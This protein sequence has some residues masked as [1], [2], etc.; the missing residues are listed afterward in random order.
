LTLDFA[1]SETPNHRE[2]E[3]MQHL[4]AGGWVKAIM[5]PRGGPILI[6]K[7]LNKGWIEKCGDGRELAYRITEE[8][9]AAKKAPVKIL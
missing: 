2:R 9:L 1:K 4:R 5:I 3:F 7:L 8:G 6:E